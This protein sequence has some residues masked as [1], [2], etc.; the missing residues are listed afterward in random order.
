LEEEVE[1]EEA[2]VETVVELEGSRQAF[3]EESLGGY[4]AW[5][6]ASSLAV[7]F[8]ETVNLHLNKEIEVDMSAF[9]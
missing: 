6:Q 3:M 8:A 4:H 7:C 2:D 1:V 9:R 5:T